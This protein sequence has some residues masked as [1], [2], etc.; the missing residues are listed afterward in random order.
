MN[1]EPNNLSGSISKKE[2]KISGSYKDYFILP[3][4]CKVRKTK[5]CKFNELN[6]QY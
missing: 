4:V 1:H 5:M 6:K 2:K 3:S